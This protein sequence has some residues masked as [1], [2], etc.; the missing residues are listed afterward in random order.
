VDPDQEGNDMA[1]KK[2]E[3]KAPE[4]AAKTEEPQDKAAA[5][6]T[7]RRMLSKRKMVSKRAAIH[8]A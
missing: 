8:K 1:D 3:P 7:K 6:V 4:A 5:R 2:I